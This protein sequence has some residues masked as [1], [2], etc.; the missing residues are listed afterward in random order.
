MGFV[1]MVSQSTHWVSATLVPGRAAFAGPP[2]KNSVSSL[3]PQKGQVMI[4]KM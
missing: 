3:G 4:N 2:L 1:G